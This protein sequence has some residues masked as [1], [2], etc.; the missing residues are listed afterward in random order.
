MQWNEQIL[1]RRR[2]VAGR[3]MSLSKR[4]NPLSNTRTSSGPL[5][6]SSLG[7]S[8]NSNYDSLQGFYRPDT[9]EAQMRKLADYAFMLR[10]FKLA[11][12]T[13]D[14]LRTDFNNDKA[15]KYYAG[16]NEMAAISLLL[17]SSAVSSKTRTEAVD[18]MLETASYSYITRCA[19]PY[20]ALRAL[21]LGL[22][23]LRLRG[24]SASDDAARWAGRILEAKLV[25]PL[26]DALFT[27]RSSVCYAARR[28]TGSMLWGSR[29][30]K[31]ALW[32]ILAADSWLKL[33]R[34][35]QAEKCLK[36]AMALYDVDGG[37]GKQL[38]FDA[39]QQFLEEVREEIADRKREM[40]G[41]HGDDDGD[42]VNEDG[43]VDVVVEEATETLDVRPHRKSLIGVTA[44]LSTRDA[45]PLSPLSPVKLAS[46]ES[47]FRDDNFQDT[48]R[49]DTVDGPL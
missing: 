39:M 31:A 18:Q 4:W 30:R 33:D 16:A 9:P 42:G 41:L 6:G 48:G 23:L 38:P 47:R 22:E 15:W 1:S 28:G 21:S 19:A 5:A 46:E 45:P 8:S 29:R 17:S 11:Q 44:P 35:V 37:K 25:G 27:E 24:S 32:A 10:D 34:C 13:Y 2:G 36:E 3:F 40:L 43:G 14:L 26:G 20:N 7:S 49:G 12:S